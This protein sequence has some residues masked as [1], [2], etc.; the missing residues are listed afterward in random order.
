M[1][2]VKDI[3]V[4]AVIPLII[5]IFKILWSKLMVLENF[6][7]ASPKIEY[8]KLFFAQKS[9][10]ATKQDISDMLDTKFERFELRLIN[11]GRIMPLKTDHPFE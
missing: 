6:Y 1:E 2:L 9:E 3:L 4:Y 10:I 8:C 7:K 11:E 5:L